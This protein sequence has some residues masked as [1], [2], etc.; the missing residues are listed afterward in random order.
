MHFVINALQPELEI[1][2]RVLHKLIIFFKC[3]MRQ[4]NCLPICENQYIVTLQ[5]YIEGSERAKAM[6]E[7]AH[8]ENT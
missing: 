8:G 6:K 2:Y 4:S 1:V 5:S 3:S 7:N